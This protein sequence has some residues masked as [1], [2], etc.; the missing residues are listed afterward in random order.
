MDQAIR[1]K[2]RAVV[3]QC[4]KL[5]EDSTAQALQG[6][7][8]IYAGRKKGEV[9][10]EDEARMAHLT[11]ED[12][13]CRQDLLDH[14]EHIQAISYKPSEALEQ[15]VRE[16][17]FTHLN[18][19]C[20]YKMME[21]RGLIREAVS[22][23]FKSQG[24]FFYLSDHPED[25][26]LHNGGGQEKAY[27]NYLDWLGGTLSQEIGVLFNPNDPANRIYP[28]QRVL[29]EVLG[30]INGEELNGI[31]TED[32]TIGWVYQY[33]TPKELRD[34]ARKE[35]QAPRNSY[36]LAFR[37]Q[38]FTPRYVV[39][40]LTDNTLGRIWYEMRQGETSLKDRC[41]Y[42][43]RRPSEIFLK[44]GEEPPAE[45][46]EA[47]EDISQ[48]ELLK[49]PVYIAH[50]PKKDPREIK[51]LDPACGSG[52]F[53]LYCFD[54][55]QV[56]YEEAW[57]EQKTVCSRLY[58]EGAEHERQELSGLDSLAESDGP[59]SDGIRGH[60]DL[61]QRG[62]VRADQSNS[63][64]GGLDSVEHRG[65]SGTD[66]GQGVSELPVDSA[67]IAAGSGNPDSHRA[68]DS[69]SAEG[70]GG[71]SSEPGGR[72]RTSDQRALELALKEIGYDYTNSA[73]CP[74]PTA[75]SSRDAFLKAV[76]QMILKHNLHGI[77]IDLRA[78]Q[79][80]A[81]ALWLRC[82]RAYQD[83]GLKNGE[84]PKIT[85]SN[86]VCAEP[87]P[88]ETDLLKEFTATLQPKVLGQLV[89]AVFE[90]MKLAGEAGS[91]LKIEEEIRDAAITAKKEY[92]EELRRRKEQAGYLPGMAPP[93]ERTLFDFSDMTDSDFLDRAED[94][95]VAALRQ[96]A[97]KAS[98]GRGFR[99][100]LFA[101]D[102]ARGFAFVDICRKQF[103]VVLMNPPFG[104]VSPSLLGCLA[105]SYP[106]WN[107][108]IL[109]AFLER[110]YLIS[111]PKGATAAIYDRTAIVK[112][113]YED[114][115]RTVLVADNRLT[116]M[117]D[118]GWEVLD[119]NV[120]V[121]TSVLH[122][123][124][125]TDKGVFFDCR[126]MEVDEKGSRIEDS[127]SDL[128]G[129]NIRNGTVCE[130]GAS[131]QHLP[132]SV[133]GYDF[134]RFLRMAFE[135]LPSMEKSGFKANQGHALK[136]DKHF[137][138]WWEVQRPSSMGFFARMFNGAGFA[139]YSTALHDCVIAQV[140]PESLPKDSA[141]VIRNRDVQLLPG[142][143]FGKRGDYFCTH[144]LPRG[145]IFTVE[146]QSIPI[147]NREKA[148]E[149][150][151]FLNTPLAR[152]SLNKY[153]GQHKYSGYVNL[154]PYRRLYNIE[155]CKKHVAL[156]IES[157]RK[158]Q[159]LDEVQSLFVN[160][161]SSKGVTDSAATIACIIDS[162]L[163]AS[164]EAELICHEESLRTYGVSKSEQEEIESFRLRQPQIESPIG[165]VDI[166]TGCKWFCAHSEISL[167]IGNL[168]GR[169]DI[170]LAT[171]E[172]QPPELPDPFDPLPVCPPCM[173]QSPDGLPAKPEDVPSNYP[174]RIDW[175]GILVDDPGHEDDIVRRVRDVL[176]VIWP[177]DSRQRAV[178]SRQKEECTGER[179]TADCILPTA[180]SIEREASEILGVRELRDY[181]RKPGN[182]GF[183]MDHV[184]RYSK[185]RRK[186]PI[187]WYLR[188]AKGSYGLWL[189][190]HRL[191][192]DILFKALL[193][194][195]EPKIRLEED[196]LNTLRARKEAAGSSGREAKQIEKDM[197]RQEQFVSELHDFKDKLRRAANL[198][199]EPD[200]NDGVVLNIAP[201]WEFV[202][203]K[204]AKK[205][206]DELQ[207]G[208]Y[209]WSHIAY[210]LW[211]ERVKDVCKRDRSI[212]IAHGLEDICEVGTGGNHVG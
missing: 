193:N 182:G 208:K 91:L 152:Y 161:P 136:A 175:D 37:N 123:Q 185:S 69:V 164:E 102:A 18:R 147:E 85:R 108:N 137:R 98:N 20:A 120:E 209:D 154:L 99:R 158:A 142:I 83:L 86:I 64:S 93:R 138:V 28:L 41:R 140:P 43:V 15:L 156:A 6:R 58:A 97:E 46:K 104:E 181:F 66:L 124:P 197:D 129:G 179:R 68:T 35:S 88:G 190:Y 3:T 72:S 25:E 162:A 2:L 74:L 19:L 26:K 128:F 178:G 75:Y 111:L 131:F 96:Y 54:L 184:K 210:Q 62:D 202:P 134:P 21:S 146:G 172:R 144:V 8:G 203:W 71:T 132:N 212:A 87:M 116:V 90:K 55:L 118:L 199:I 187:Y 1:N 135:S 106:T 36:E 73:Y 121:T 163:K 173:L 77:D 206:W 50:R 177:Q 201:L 186:A 145:H 170:R 112:S 7:F 53:L 139:P 17:A 45:A 192:K 31:W 204:E 207:E 23:G 13:A 60:E 32:E 95:I 63:P 165:D 130:S 113:T 194:Y 119:A 42:L 115:R 51:V 82:Q 9:Q 151:G 159:S 141:T 105:R 40:F 30:V 143:C 47:R 183:W 70:E 126:E 191:D 196:R 195:V 14:L 80:A 29:D 76:P 48:E 122:H 59:R 65:R 160:K 38:F 188:S 94:E 22:R 114:F 198:H 78:T 39:E 174:L 107:K 127:V 24:F 12:R 117:A 16:I 33:F 103:D 84:H 101:E 56:I 200:L 67:R 155:K 5:L 166:L 189:Y 153:C 81:L 125:A 211:P 171:G 100:R 148:L 10:I 169:W 61:S 133:V 92:Q 180:Y 52:H 11:E 150:L 34:K 27:R 57:E 44:E 49:Q 79:I 167:A 157:L 4:R 176:E 89:E 205:Y 110:G 109:C 149:A 168:F